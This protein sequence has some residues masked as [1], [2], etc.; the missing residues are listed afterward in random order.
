MRSISVKINFLFSFLFFFQSY[1]QLADKNTKQKIP[2]S[3]GSGVNST[4]GELSPVISADGKTVYFVR[5]SHEKNLAKQ[6][7]W[8][9][10]LDEKGKWM[11]ASHPLAPINTGIS[12][13]IFNIT[14]DGNQLLVRGAYN[15]G[16][17][18]SA[19]IS[20][21]S[22]DKYGAWKNPEKMD[23]PNYAELA[24]MGKYNG[25]FLCNDGKTVLMY[26]TD[27]LNEGKGD[28][29]VSHLKEDEKKSK[30]RLTKKLGKLIGS[31]ISQGKWTMP[32]KI[33]NLNTIK[34]DEIAPFMAA[35]GVTLYFSSDRKG[36]FGSNDI[37]MS[38][39]LDSTW[40]KW[41]EPVNL[42]PEINS[43][44]WDCYY[45]MD[46]KGEM[47]YLVSFNNSL[48]ASDIV[49]VQ[50]AEPK[51]PDPV[52]LI[53]GKVFDAETGD[54]IGCSI[55]YED[56]AKGKNVGF[57]QSDPS[58]GEYKIILPYGKNYGFM[59]SAANYLSVA[60]HI[61]LIKV[62]EYQEINRDLFMVPA[63]IGSTIRLNN[64][65]FD[66]AKADLRSESFPELDR[67]VNCLNEN[68]KMEIEIR[69][70]T[71]NVGGHDANVNLSN[72]RAASVRAYLINK[73]INE[74]RV[75][76]IG[77]GET[78]PLKK[79]DT[80]KNRQINRRVEFVILKNS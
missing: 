13:C 31:S 40:K 56:L 39:R 16:D 70:H 79:N 9:S 73:G 62:S 30:S 41:S 1:S 15:K 74:S 18:E 2:V 46:A 17:F 76:S 22:K 63:K 60:D 48:G 72:D 28:I 34:N 59:G 45:T 77:Y 11:E 4:T 53:Y 25:A 71:D 66:F 23:I 64:I 7:V 10:R 61:D 26:F 55:N 14:P 80:D 50:L 3:L 58:N 67:L 54:V 78:K 8:F 57:A 49:K 75:R 20:I 27:D 6:D 21:I 24:A 43:E 68:P 47:A 69:G 51:R 42:G 36:G 35:D 19:G 37:W 29:Y 38:K 33:G 12:S 44:E 5:D 65:F 52:V 32:E